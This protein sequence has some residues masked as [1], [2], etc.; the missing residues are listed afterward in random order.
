[1]KAC[2]VIVEYNPFHNGHRYHLQQAREQTSADVIVAVMSGNFLQRGEPAI[3]DKWTRAE[4]ALLQGA[5]LVIELPFAYAVQSADYF[6]AGAIKLLQALQVESLVFG[7]DVK[8][9]VDYQGF[10]AFVAS[11]QAEIDARYQ[12]MRNNGQSYPQQMT[13]LFRELLGLPLDFSSP[14]HILGLSYAKEN[15]KY[16]QPM[17][18]IPIHREHAGY[19]DETIQGTIAS[20][21]AI[22]KG[23]EAG[24]DVALTMPKTSWGL[25]QTQPL[26][27][28]QNFWPLLRYQLL[29]QTP[30][31]LRRIYQMTE[32]IE[33]RLKSAAEKA[34]TFAAFIEAVKTKRYTWTRLQRLCCYILG[35]VTENEIQGTWQNTFIHVLGFT[36]KGQQFLKERKKTADLP[37]L[38]RIGRDTSNFSLDEK[39][40]HLY[41][42]GSPKISEQVYGRFPLQR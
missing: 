29:V 3:V 6:A 39:I 31:D 8:E 5:D 15:A 32:G 16:S 10:G 36:S 33:Y 21:T 37:I 28:W 7:T 35:Q 34:E 22:R 11:H 26:I 19:H 14:N 30:S 25:L 13:A 4:M 20:A 9:T 1:M 2:G 23:L 41:Q 42:L 38:T 40:S 27:S 18:L 12:A 17:T 24:S